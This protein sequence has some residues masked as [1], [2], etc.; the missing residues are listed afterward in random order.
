MKLRSNINRTRKTLGDF[1]AE[2]ASAGATC[3]GA[4]AA[5]AVG[6]VGIPPKIRRKANR[7]SRKKN[8]NKP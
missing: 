8:K 6:S 3:S 5:N 4:I 1:L 2:V 7:T